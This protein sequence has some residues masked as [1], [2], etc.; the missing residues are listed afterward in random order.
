MWDLINDCEWQPWR[1]L[2]KTEKN[3]VGQKSTCFGDLMKSYWLIPSSEKWCALWE[4]RVLDICV[5]NSIP[6]ME[7]YSVHFQSG[8]F[9]DINICAPEPGRR[10]EC[11]SWKS[12]YKAL[13]EKEQCI[14][15]SFILQTLTKPSSC[16]KLH[17]QRPK[18]Q[19]LMCMTSQCR[20][21]NV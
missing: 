9:C 10:N 15:S 12:L 21:W 19:S 4:V 11:P 8:L 6:T 16:P 20:R 17:L 3:L 18:R 2:Q 1:N 7:L 5:L 13:F 14:K